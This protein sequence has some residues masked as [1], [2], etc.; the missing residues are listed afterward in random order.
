M[1][2]EGEILNGRYCIR[3]I[4]GSGGSGCVYLATDINIG[5]YWALKE[6][7]ISCLHG[8]EI[9][10]G[11]IQFLKAFN[12]PMFPRIT[13]AWKDDNAYYIVSDYIEGI[14][15]GRL[16]K[17]GPLSKRKTYLLLLQVA[18]AIEY[19]HNR[20]PVILYLDLKPDN[21]LIKPD[22][23][24]SL[25]DFG[26][27]RSINK[28]TMNY[29]TRGFA[30]PEQYAAGNDIDETADVYAF[31]ATY[32][33][34][35]TGEY[36]NPQ[37]EILESDV[38]K[39]K[40]LS[41]KEK[42]F[43]TNCIYADP[44]KRTRTMTIVLKNL[45]MLNSPKRFIIILISIFL[46]VIVMA[47]SSYKTNNRKEVQ[48][49]SILQEIV[50]ESDGFGY[51]PEELKMM[52]LCVNSGDLNRE[53]EEFFSFEIGRCYFEKYG[54]FREAKRYF[55][56]I[57]ENRWPQREYYL[58][59]CEFQTSFDVDTTE[60]SDCLVEFEKIVYMMPDCEEK[61][62]NLLFIAFCYEEY[63]A[64]GSIEQQKGDIILQNA[65]DSLC[66]KDGGRE[67]EWRETVKKEIKR[68]QHIGGL[69][70]EL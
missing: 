32:Y 70:T 7:D 27:S 60:I 43:I 45:N 67:N 40:R 12:H 57:D 54:D 2:N 30:P 36:P 6:V 51:S 35:R 61:Y 68:R 4:I 58:K 56:R 24:V 26:I 42:K 41:L 9:A 17:M 3:K 38:L 46:T 29:G 28:G 1:H 50:A 52:S 18:H 48:Y 31:A 13:D 34:C 62:R 22:G 55:E 8:H 33:T 11:E 59:L 20:N 53:E 39:S 23:K 47:V 37:S 21:I 63:F 10:E 16:L 14:S 44:G 5:K 49:I 66:T 64:K 25:I 15:L 65:Y 69:D 19:L